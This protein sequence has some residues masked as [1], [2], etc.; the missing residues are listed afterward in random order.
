MQ[1]ILKCG[2]V[3]KAFYGEDTYEKGI[4]YFFLSRYFI[5]HGNTF[6]LSVLFSIHCLNKLIRICKF[7]KIIIGKLN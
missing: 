6:K 3:F 5:N 1:S 4:E 7:I 2:D